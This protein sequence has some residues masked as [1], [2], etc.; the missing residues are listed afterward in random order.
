[1][2]LKGKTWISFLLWS[3]GLKKVWYVLL[4]YNTKNKRELRG[5]TATADLALVEI[6]YQRRKRGPVDFSFSLNLRKRE[7]NSSSVVTVV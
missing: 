3:I 6:G 5:N 2:H 1:M 4:L 7:S